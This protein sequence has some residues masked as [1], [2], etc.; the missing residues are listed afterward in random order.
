MYIL[1]ANTEGCL[2]IELWCLQFC[3]RSDSRQ[4]SRLS[5]YYGWQQKADDHWILSNN[6]IC[7]SLLCCIYQKGHFNQQPSSFSGSGWHLGELTWCLGSFHARYLS[8]VM[9]LKFTRDSHLRRYNRLLSY[10]LP[11]ELEKLKYVPALMCADR[12]LCNTLHRL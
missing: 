10:S 3:R 12:M 5:F 1:Q 7:S 4:E 11:Q 2:R 8:Q 6:G 9:R